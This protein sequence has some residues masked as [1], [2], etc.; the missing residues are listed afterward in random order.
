MRA[1]FTDVKKTLILL[2]NLRIGHMRRWR[3]DELGYMSSTPYYEFGTVGANGLKSNL[4]FYVES[5]D[6][7]SVRVVKL[8]LIA[9]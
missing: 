2:S 4:A 1:Y 6:P 5:P 7:N 9:E 3:S 8:M